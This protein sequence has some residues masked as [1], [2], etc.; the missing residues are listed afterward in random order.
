MIQIECLHGTK[1]F[2]PVRDLILQRVNG[3]WL[4]DHPHHAILFRN[5]FIVNLFKGLNVVRHSRTPKTDLSVDSL[6]MFFF[7]ANCI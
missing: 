7:K 3:V 4:L 6:R 5:A 1:A 2:D